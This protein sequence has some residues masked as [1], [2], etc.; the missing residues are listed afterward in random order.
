MAIDKLYISHLNYDWNGH[1]SKLLNQGNL[2]KESMSSAK[3]IFHTSIQDIGFDNIE[4]V[5]RSANKII[6]VDL[7]LYADGIPPDEEYFQY[8]RLIREL[9]K[10]KHKVENFDWVSELNYNF[11]D[12]TVN[13]RTTNNPVLWTAGCSVTHGI[14]VDRADRWGSI[15][16]SRLNVPEISLAQPGQSIAWCADQILRS[17]IRSGDIVVWGLT[18][19]ARV[20]YAKKWELWSCPAGHYDSCLPPALQHYNLDYF[21]SQTKFVYAIKNILQVK[22]YC[23]KIH[24]QLYL[25]N[26]LDTTWLHVVFDSL[27]TYIDF[28]VNK[29]HNES[30]TF[31]DRGTDNSHPGPK[32]HLLYA[33]QILN[34][35][36]ENNHV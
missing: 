13:Q 30:L 31:L 9:F 4:N 15:L 25:A 19:I 5:V 11:F 10:V 6:L 16:S 3:N 20:E 7:N 28:C 22:N 18:N 36:K 29:T 21:T 24:A 26:L 27:P 32:Q 34:L 33:E 14:G 17:D 8:G 1:E 35:I 23:E 2:S 12:N